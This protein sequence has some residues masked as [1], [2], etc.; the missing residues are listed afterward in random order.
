MIRIFTTNGTLLG[1]SEGTTIDQGR[2]VAALTSRSWRT[3]H[4][5]I[6]H[7]SGN[8]ADP[9]PFKM[10]VQTTPYGKYEDGLKSMFAEVN[11]FLAAVHDVK[12]RL[13]V[14]AMQ[15][16]KDM[17]SSIDE[18]TE[19]VSVVQASN[20][21]E[22]ADEETDVEQAMQNASDSSSGSH[23]STSTEGNNSIQTNNATKRDIL[24]A[25]AEGMADLLVQDLSDFVMPSEFY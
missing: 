20:E 15:P 25:K 24:M 22:T 21:T 3:N 1:Y 2:T 14:A 7:D 23:L 4:D 12:E 17:E 9:G 11:G 8:L 13:L 10:N 6:I 16:V 19:E 18:V 5:L